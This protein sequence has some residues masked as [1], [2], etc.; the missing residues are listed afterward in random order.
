M[1]GADCE[2][3]QVQLS[4]PPPQS[5]RFG[6]AVGRL[7]LTLKECPRVLV[8]C[9]GLAQPNIKKPGRSKTGAIA[10]R[11]SKSTNRN[12]PMGDSHGY[13][14][15]GCTRKPGLSPCGSVNQECC[16]SQN[17]NSQAIR[18]IRLAHE[19]APTKKEQK[20][21]IENQLSCG[22]FGERSQD[23]RHQL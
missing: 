10:L 23:Q 3:E 17:E 2:F 1:V 11:F 14:R 19:C 13:C 15:A 6:T 21:F 12:E 9:E 18:P 7:T 8:D 20:L 22:V 16:R 4:N 5:G